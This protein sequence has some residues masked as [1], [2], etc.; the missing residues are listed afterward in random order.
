MWKLCQYLFHFFRSRLIIFF[1]MMVLM[2]FTFCRFPRTVFEKIWHPSAVN[3]NIII[4]T[5]RSI[6]LIKFQFLV[7]WSFIILFFPSFPVFIWYA[8]VL[9]TS[10]CTVIKVSNLPEHAIYTGNPLNRC[11]SQS[12]PCAWITFSHDNYGDVH[13]REIGSWDK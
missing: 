1:T 3:R 4:W 5:I 7:L 10:T 8:Y 9:F 6:F 12:L 2:L 13:G 11:F